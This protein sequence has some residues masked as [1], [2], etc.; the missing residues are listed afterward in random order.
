[1]K[2]I[3]LNNHLKNKIMKTFVTSLILMVSLINNA[4]NTYIKFKVDDKESKYIMYPPGTKFE[5][6]TKEGY[7]QMKNSEN[8]YK[9]YI[10]S[11]GFRLYVYPTYKSEKD[12]YH[13]EKGASLELVLT[14]HFKDNDSNNLNYNHNSL[15]GLKKITD[16][17]SL[18]SK[19]NLYF[20]LSNGIEFSYVDGKYNATLNN[21]YLDIKG[22]YVIN[23][24]LGTLKI[25]F[26]PN[27]GETWWVFESKE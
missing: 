16:S 19:K 1:M 25:S 24:K 20:K 5:V 23:S 11:E 10:E 2:K 26:N 14:K 15:T 17:K 18:E 13:L 9:L 4:Q 21:K 6:K 8:P 12:V 7:I 3:E 27:N 22:K